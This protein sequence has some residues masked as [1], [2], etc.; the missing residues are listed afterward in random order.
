MLVT[1]STEK[2]ERQE[3]TSEVTEERWF[4]LFKTYFEDVILCMAIV[5]S[6]QQ[7]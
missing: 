3:L 4:C 6:R 2:V 5:C 7:K 1:V